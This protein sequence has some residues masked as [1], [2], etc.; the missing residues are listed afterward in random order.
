[1]NFLLMW[2]RIRVIRSEMGRIIL[3]YVLIR[4][5]MGRLRTSKPLE[6]LLK[7][8][9]KFRRFCLNR[10]LRADW[11]SISKDRTTFSNARFSLVQILEILDHLRIF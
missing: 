4:P 8:Q 1:M 2:Y 3:G 9:E 6:P 10:M 7:I 11:S 5:Q